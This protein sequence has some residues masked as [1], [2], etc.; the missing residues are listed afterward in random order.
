MPYIGSSGAKFHLDGP[1]GSA[2]R[3]NANGLAIIVIAAALLLSVVALVRLGS[4]ASAAVAAVSAATPAST[5]VPSNQSD[6]AMTAATAAAV[7]SQNTAVETA[8]DEAP[9]S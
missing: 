3:S 7:R 9:V 8:S 2:K 6:I 1:H 5:F 4:A